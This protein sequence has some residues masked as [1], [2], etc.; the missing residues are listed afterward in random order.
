[1]SSTLSSTSNHSGPAVAVA[2]S[3]GGRTTL[4]SP[5]IGMPAQERKAL[6]ENT[7]KVTIV[8]TDADTSQTFFISDVPKRMLML[9]SPAAAR[10]FRSA[11][12]N[13]GAA[14]NKP[15][16]KNKQPIYDLG[17]VAQLAPSAIKYVISALV[18]A[19]RM[20]DPND[21]NSDNGD[22]STTTTTAAASINPD[23]SAFMPPA[24]PEPYVLR[25][26]KCFVAAQKL[27]VRC[28][29]YAW[30]GAIMD[31]VRAAN[32]TADEFVYMH[33]AFG[34]E[35]EPLLLRHVL[36]VVAYAELTDEEEHPETLKINRYVYGSQPSLAPVKKAVEVEVERK[37]VAREEERARRQARWEERERA[38]KEWAER[39]ERREEE[40]EEQKREEMQK[41]DAEQ[42]LQKKKKD[43]QKLT[44]RER[45]A[46]KQERMEQARLG[47]RALT[48]KEVEAMGKHHGP[49][50]ATVSNKLR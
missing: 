32:V 9:F 6:V 48:D 38:R 15:Q 25:H 31:A 34:E 13:N 29:R 30:R 17:T 16:Q 39:K 50:T 12:D 33:R 26:L 11:R 3:G 28:V 18:S 8:W 35:G 45:L 36:H 1:M 24:Y 4:K 42:L 7:D 20:P 44:K 27:G 19:C 14:A 10:F 5:L 21:N 43:G 41:K 40:E 2:G 49:S 37:L 47:E 22:S 23:A 46:K